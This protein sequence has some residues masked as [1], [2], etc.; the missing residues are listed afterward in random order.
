[1]S[2]PPTGNEAAKSS[3]AVELSLGLK[4]GS[5]RF[6]RV[7]GSGK[8][9]MRPVTDIEAERLKN[10]AKGGASAKLVEYRRKKRAADEVTRKVRMEEVVR[11]NPL[12]Y[13]MVDGEIVEL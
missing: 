7:K 10:N 13:K 6:G 1:M 4:K 9:E 11:L 3:A 2:S 12:K 5:S 8:D